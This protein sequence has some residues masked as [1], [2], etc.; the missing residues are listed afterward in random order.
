MWAQAGGLR[1]LPLLQT[2]AANPLQAHLPRVKGEIEVA[3]G[4]RQA[5]LVLDA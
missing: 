2:P 4:Q 5:P 3:A 1:Y